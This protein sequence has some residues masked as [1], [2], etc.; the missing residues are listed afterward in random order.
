MFDYMYYRISKLFL[1]PILNGKKAK[2]V[3]EG[4]SGGWSIMALFSGGFVYGIMYWGFGY[5][6]TRNF[7]QIASVLIL[8]LNIIIFSRKGLMIKLHNKYKNENKIKKIL[9]GWLVFLS[10]I[11]VV[12]VQFIWALKRQKEGIEFQ[13]FINEWVGRLI[14][15]N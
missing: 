3:K 1:H 11:F 4:T 2:S 9:K 15:S 10:I 7:L 12:F 8:V 14:S 6:I 13:G 5:P